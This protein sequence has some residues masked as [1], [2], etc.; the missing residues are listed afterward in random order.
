MLNCANNTAAQPISSGV[1]QKLL[2]VPCHPAQKQTDRSL[3]HHFFISCS[4]IPCQ[5]LAEFKALPVCKGAGHM[6][7]GQV[8]KEWV[9]CESVVKSCHECR[10][11]AHSLWQ[12]QTASTA[13]L[14]SKSKP[15]QL[16]SAPATMTPAL[17]QLCWP[18]LLQSHIALL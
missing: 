9:Q 16:R 4:H 11:C 6:G 3:K 13:A 12:R 14:R 2:V 7:H 5:V 8:N 15:W 10:M 17:P 1:A 18:H